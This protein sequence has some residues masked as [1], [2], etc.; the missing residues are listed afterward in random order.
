MVNDEDGVFNFEEFFL[1]EDIYCYGSE[2]DID[3]PDAPVVDVIRIDMNP[4]SIPLYVKSY[5]YQNSGGVFLVSLIHLFQSLENNDYTDARPYF[6]HTQGLVVYYLRKLAQHGLVKIMVKEKCKSMYLSDG[7]YCALG[8]RTSL[9]K[10]TMYDILFV[11]L[12]DLEE[13]DIP[14]II[15]VMHSLHI[16][17][18]NFRFKTINGK[19]VVKYS[20]RNFIKGICALP[21]GGKELVLS[22]KRRKIDKK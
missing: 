22:L 5:L 4:N 19:L 17:S 18:E 11:K 2:E 10:K 6:A 20:G 15:D 16:D 1:E 13:S 7:Y 14:F 21:R 12:R 8:S 9:N 3:S